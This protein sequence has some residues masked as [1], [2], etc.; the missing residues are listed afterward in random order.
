MR[1]LFALW[2]F[3]CLLQGQAGG[4]PTISPFRIP[5]YGG[6][7][8]AY[9]ALSRIPGHPTVPQ[10]EE[11]ERVRC[12]PLRGSGQAIAEVGFCFRCDLAKADVRQPHGARNA[13]MRR[14]VPQSA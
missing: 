12:V 14:R 7:A 9:G 8:I 13:F 4:L 3:P 11:D 1:Q 10:T 5:V 2:T 6:I